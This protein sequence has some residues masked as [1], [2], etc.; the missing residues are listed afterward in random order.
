[1][2]SLQDKVSMNRNRASN[3]IS[4]VEIVK[5]VYYEKEI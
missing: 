5:A 1:M 2:D 4:M 3:T